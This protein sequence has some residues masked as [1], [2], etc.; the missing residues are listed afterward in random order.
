[1]W[2]KLCYLIVSFEQIRLITMAYYNLNKSISELKLETESKIN[3][4]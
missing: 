4:N 2:F 1:M 3:K